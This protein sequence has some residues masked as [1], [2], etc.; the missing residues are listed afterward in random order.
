MPPH[1]RFVSND[2]IR[3]RYLDNDP[4]DPAGLPVLFVP[5]VTDFAD[6]YLEVFE[7]F[8][9]RRLVVIELRGRGGSDAPPTGYSVKELASDVECV[10]GAAG[11]TRFHVMTFS[12]GTTPALEVCIARPDKVVTLS[13]GDYLAAEIGLG[14]AFVDSQWASR[15]RGRLMPERVQRHVLEQIQEASVSRELW[16]EV[17]GLGIPVL[18]ARGTEG[19][20]VSDEHVERY[21]QRIPG[22]EVVTVAGAAHDLFRLDRTAYPRAVLD[23]IARRAAGT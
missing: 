22:V 16:D 3:L 9:A 4:T 21:R 1:E 20:I 19:G 11:L 2:G 18:V 12:R 6:E 10:I 8:G 13:I 17:A 23:F 15:F 7:L 14:P 5:G